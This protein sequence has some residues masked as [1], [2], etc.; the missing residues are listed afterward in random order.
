MPIREFVWVEDGDWRLLPVASTKKCR[1][2]RC[3]NRGVAELLRSWGR[4]PGRWW[5]YCP[6]HM[7][8]RRIHCGRVEI[9]VHPDSDAAKS[10]L[11]RLKP[12]P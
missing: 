10:G 7:Y 9:Q 6:D 11:V 5:A 3:P 4:T 2:V 1:M 12:A 8:G